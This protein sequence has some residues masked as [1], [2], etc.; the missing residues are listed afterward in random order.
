LSVPRSRLKDRWDRAFAIAS[1]R[2]WNSLPVYI[3]AAQSQ[4]VLN[5][6]LKRFFFQCPCYLSCLLFSTL[7]RLVCC[8]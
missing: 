6:L 4:T 2:L 7:V 5:P 8:F 3:R 1:P